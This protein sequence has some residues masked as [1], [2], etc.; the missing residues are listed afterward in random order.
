[1]EYTNTI[2]YC[3]VVNKVWGELSYKLLKLCPTPVSEIEKAFGILSEKPTPGIFVRNWLTYKLRKAIEVVERE[4]Y[5][6]NFNVIIKIKRQLQC[7]MERE[8]DQ[9]LFSFSYENKT[10]IFDK[11]YAYK[12]VLCA[13]Q[14]GK[15][16]KINDIFR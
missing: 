5:Y 9:K 16:Y 8:L 2:F 3:N 12:N 4:A 15:S 1:M 13:S 10:E 14:D 11:F 6:S 7:S